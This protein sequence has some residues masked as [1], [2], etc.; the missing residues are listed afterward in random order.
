[1]D[2]LFFCNLVCEHAD[3]V[4]AATLTKNIV[5][6]MNLVIELVTPGDAFTLPSIPCAGLGQRLVVIQ[7]LRCLLVTV[8][9]LDRHNVKPLLVGV[10]WCSEPSV[11]L[12]PAMRGGQQPGLEPDHIGQEPPDCNSARTGRCSPSMRRTSPSPPWS[13]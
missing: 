3:E 6:K 9:V 1:M 10:L 11:P 8:T 13:T 7:T 4:V 2:W 12:V 5:H